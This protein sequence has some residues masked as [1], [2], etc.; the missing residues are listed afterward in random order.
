[1]NLA[2]YAD[3]SSSYTSA[4]LAADCFSSEA[5]ETAAFAYQFAEGMIENDVIPVYGHFPG[6]GATVNDP[7]HEKIVI[8][9]EDDELYAT[10]MLPFRQAIAAGMPCIM[11]SSARYPALDQ[12]REACF[13]Y[14]IVTGILRNEFG[15]DGIIITDY[16]NTDIIK[17]AYSA[18]E[19]AALAIHAGCDMILMSS[20]PQNAVKAIEEAVKN[21]DISL[22]RIDNSVLRILKIKLEY[23][24]IPF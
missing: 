21:G 16:M 22:E 7:W 23:G 24:I 5:D 18:K 19:S 20:N 11:M 13:S 3:L 10:D 1:M 14:T 6:I 12:S 15:F 4:Y 8:N 9:K 17:E 2:P